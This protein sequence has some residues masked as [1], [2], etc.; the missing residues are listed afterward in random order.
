[1]ISTLY[2]DQIVKP[3]LD[4]GETRSVKIGVR[5]GRCLSSILFNLYSKHLTSQA[6][7][8][9]GDFKIGGL[10]IRTAKYADDLVLL[11]QE[12]P[13]LQGML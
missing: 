4:P 1:V 11:A 6:P 8:E 5:Q 3:K 13:V 9:F 2:V 7:E 12:E 10:V